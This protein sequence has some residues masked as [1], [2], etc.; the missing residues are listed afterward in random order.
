MKKILF[1]MMAVAVLAASC[2]KELVEEPV[3]NDEAKVTF[4]V[5]TPEIA[6][7]AYS[8]GMTATVLQYAVYDENGEELTALTKTDAT[9]K[10]ST[11]VELQLTTGNTYS[12][13]FWA[14]AENA[15]Y[16][17]DFAKKTM[18]VNY[19]NAVCNDE[20]RDAFY[21]YHTFTVTGAQTETIELRRPF[22]QLN[23]LTTKESL[24]PVQ[25][26][27]TSS[28]A[29]DVETSE[30]K[31]IG[32][33]A[34][35][36]TLTGVSPAEDA[37]IVYE[38]AATPAKQGQATLTVGAKDAGITGTLLGVGT[39]T[40]TFTMKNLVEGDTIDVSLKPGEGVLLELTNYK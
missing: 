39:G 18:T 23:L 5:N 10:G 19:N 15:P 14:A 25:S 29:I 2:A 1:G 38:M 26:G 40:A 33:G 7:R 11:T 4:S 22:A 13:I 21:K 16:T 34:S 9:I 3:L 37:T 6:T 31:V 36:N 8:D 32:L 12:V 28:Y 27:Q 17:V 30:V 24:T 35:F 20:A